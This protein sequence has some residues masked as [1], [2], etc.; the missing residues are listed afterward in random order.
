[1]CAVLMDQ[2]KDKIQNLI[3]NL[4]YP[5]NHFFL[6]DR[7]RNSDILRKMVMTYAWLG[8]DITIISD[9]LKK[10]RSIDNGIF[11]S[12]KYHQNL[13][14]FTF[15][16][17]LLAGIYKSTGS[18]E[19]KPY[20]SYEPTDNAQ[21]G[22]VFEYAI[23]SPHTSKIYNIEIK[24]VTCDPCVKN[25]PETLLFGDRAKFIKY[26]FEKIEDV[27]DNVPPGYNLILSQF[28]PIKDAITKISDKFK[29]GDFCNIGVIVGQFA[30]SIEEFYSYFFNLKYGIIFNHKT[31]KYI[32]NFDALVFFSLTPDTDP[33]MDSVY[34][35][36]HTFTALLTDRIPENDL[37]LF[38]LNNIGYSLGIGVNPAIQQEA[39]KEVGRTVLR[40]TKNNNMFFF[41]EHLSEDTIEQYMSEIED[42][43]S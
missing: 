1:M 32:K 6:D 18:V 43:I 3:N 37:Y 42:I 24:T 25:G 8:G 15:L 35:R 22:K 2:V 31:R 5:P 23:T 36:R 7:F 9:L 27:Q 28:R 4:D 11:C 10:M 30:P 34:E 40:I 19:L 14:E 39:E 16:F 26:Y 41:P 17:Y 21:G 12:I 38:R 29:T 20:I 33:L 13:S